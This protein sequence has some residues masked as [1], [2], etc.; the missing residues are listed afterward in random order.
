MKDKLKYLCS[1]LLNWANNIFKLATL[2]NLLLFFVTHQ[3]RSLA[4]RLLGI[5]LERI[6]PEQR[7]HIDFTYINRLI[8]WN[9]LGQALSGLLPFLD[10][11][12]IKGMFQ[13]SQKLTQF[14]TLDEK[15]I[16]ADAW[17]GICGA[18]QVCMPFRS[19]QCHHIYCYYCIQSKLEEEDD[20]PWKCV[21]C[22]KPV[23]SI[24]AY[25]LASAL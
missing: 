23:E 14:M 16:N 9:A 25:Q 2:L 13:M 6:D 5:G 10:I 3:K 4:E 7:R 17:C 15:D 24:E 22:S 1:R 19:K 18:T 11:G 8:V 12:K 20:Q 21:K